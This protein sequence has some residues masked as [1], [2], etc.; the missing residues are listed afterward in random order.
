MPTCNICNS[1]DFRWCGQRNNPTA[2]PGAS[3]AVHQDK[4]NIPPQCAA[5]EGVERHRII[6][7]L[8]DERHLNQSQKILLTSNDPSILYLP[9]DR[10]EQ[11]IFGEKNSFD[12]REIPRDSSTY[13]LIMCV[14]ILEH[15][16]DDF[17][18]FKELCR[19]LTPY[20]TLLW[21]VPSPSIVRETEEY[22]VPESHYGHVRLYGKDFID[23]IKIWDE[24]V[25]V[26]TEVV[27]KTDEVT[28]FED[29]I[30]ITKHVQ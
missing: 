19:I 18:A 21:S 24:S 7:K 25:G 22:D 5:C 13:D 16:K 1:T 9:T 28:D 11:S 23:T 8:Y 26:T 4:P 20:G 2:P 10:V 17:L 3:L 30:F 6:K 29:V 27:Y 14:H 12:L 15:V